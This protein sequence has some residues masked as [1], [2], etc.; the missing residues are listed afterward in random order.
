[1]LALDQAEIGLD[2]AAAHQCHKTEPA[3]MRQQVELARDVVAAD[4]VEDRIDAAAIGEI[5]ADLHEILSAVVDRDIGTIIAARA[6]FF[7]GAGGGPPNALSS[8]IAVT[9]M[10]LDPP[11]TR[12]TSPACRRIRSNTLVHTVQNVL[13]RPPA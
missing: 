6:A 1:M 3:L 4:H 10:L 8:W 7:V 5:L 12:N 9:P 11:C 2:L 13:S